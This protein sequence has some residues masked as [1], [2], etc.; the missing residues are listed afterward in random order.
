MG[1]RGE[2]ACYP[3]DPHASVALASWFA[4]NVPRVLREP[5][6]DPC[7]GPGLLLEGLGL[8]PALRRAIEVERHHERELRRRLPVPAS[9][10]ITDALTVEWG[11][12]VHVV[13]NPPFGNEL[14]TEF[15][16]RGLRHVER[17]G[18]VLA[19][20]ALATWWHSDAF[21]AGK[22]RS[23]LRR[24]SHVLVPSQRVSCDGTGRGDMR[25]I[26]WLVWTG[27]TGETRVEWLPPSTPSAGLLA[28]HRRLASAE[29]P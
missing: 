21:R 8:P 7:A 5:T 24:P 12:A 19:V 2:L 11:S 27:D 13:M 1:K 29:G 26:D 23:A 25:A 9:V 14:M 15:V 18:G 16:R 4:R 20:L 22:A 6:L 10:R 3:T 28:E 17:T